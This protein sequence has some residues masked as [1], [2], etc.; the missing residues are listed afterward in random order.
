MKYKVIRSYKNAC[1]AIRRNKNDAQIV[2]LRN[3]RRP[4]GR[5]RSTWESNNNAISKEY[6]PKLFLWTGFSLAEVILRLR[7]LVSAGNRFQ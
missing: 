6:G 7:E 2:T 5:T 1:S 4:F 3:E